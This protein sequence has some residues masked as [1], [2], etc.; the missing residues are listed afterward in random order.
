[1]RVLL[2]HNFYRSS[3]PSGEDGV[4]RNER[5]LLENSDVEIVSYEKFN[6]DLDDST[7]TNKLKIAL[8]SA[9]SDKSYRELSALI[10]KTRPDV[11]HFHSL[12][13]QISPSAYA[14]CFDSGVPVIHTLHNYRPI[15]PGAMLIRN[16][17]PCEDCVGTNL[18]S[19]LRHR[20][21]RNSILATGANAWQITRNRWTKTYQ[22]VSRYIALTEFAASRYVKAGF[23][24][25]KI[26]V[27]P[28]FLP[29]GSLPGER[30]VA[31][32][33]VFVGRLSE[34]KGVRTLLKAWQSVPSLKLKILGEGLLREELEREATANALDVEFLGFVPNEDA[35][36]IIRNA[37]VQVIPSEWYEGFPMV[38]LEAYALGVPVVA[39]R[40][41]S[42]EEVIEQGVT[43]LRF[44]P[45]DAADLAA[46]VNRLVADDGQLREMSQNALAI[47][48]AKYT[49]EV[50]I[51]LLL[52]IY[53]E[54]MDR[55]ATQEV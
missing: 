20:C 13:P 6:D 5:A 54:V 24:P 17:K 46:T 42:L 38:V 16:G 23:D 34:E 19:S 27:K 3:A 40:I 12:F 47:F 26:V 51:D 8:D 14:A 45:G 7:L 28:N 37:K 32:Y 33:A 50:N 41:G 22:K 48:N 18:L 11:A 53:A 29:G 31:D 44:T 35:L 49:A 2:G 52:S 15:C 9:W 4:Y 25:E 43:G 55:K 10:K 30:H 36:E 1:M 39:S 21:Y